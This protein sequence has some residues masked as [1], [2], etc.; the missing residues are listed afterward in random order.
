M[1]VIKY[2]AELDVLII[3]STFFFFFEKLKLNNSSKIRYLIQIK[4][5]LNSNFDVSS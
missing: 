2:L 3:V 4:K 5:E 1:R